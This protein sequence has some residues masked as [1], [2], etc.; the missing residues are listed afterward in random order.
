MNIEINLA[1]GHFTM[2]TPFNKT[3]YVLQT[4]DF[5]GFKLD[6]GQKVYLL[7]DSL[8][9]GSYNLLQQAKSEMPLS[10]KLRNLIS[11]N[12]VVIY[13]AKEYQTDL[14]IRTLYDFSLATLT[15]PRLEVLDAA[16][17]A[18]LLKPKHTMEISALNERYAAT[19]NE[20]YLL[21]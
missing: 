9:T 3:E 17:R 15:A 10:E 6:A 19:K 11:I 2:A 13:L 16:T 5:S 1:G 4:E 18:S 12:K 8:R 21:Q 7:P 20:D 14:I